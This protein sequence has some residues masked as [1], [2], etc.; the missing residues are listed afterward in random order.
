MGSPTISFAKYPS[1][2]RHDRAHEWLVMRSQFGLA[3]NT[4]DAYARALSS[5]FAFSEKVKITPELSNRADVAK[6]INEERERG[7]ANAT[8]FLRLTALRLFG[9]LAW[10]I[11]LQC[12]GSSAQNDSTA[13]RSVP[14]P[15]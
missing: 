1:L 7:I 8:I 3:L 13:I 6:W 2:L 11:S 4:I 9:C 10:L 14:L 12:S 5:Y 15:R